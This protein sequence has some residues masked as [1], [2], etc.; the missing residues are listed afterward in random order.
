[1]W[2]L[3]QLHTRHWQGLSQSVDRLLH[4][5][6]AEVGQ[7]L[8]PG[9]Q[10]GYQRRLDD[11]MDWIEEQLDQPLSVDM[12]AE[13]G[14]LS[15][16]RLFQLF[17]QHLHQSPMQYVQT[18]RMDRARAYLKNPY[19]SVKQV[20]TRCGYPDANLFVRTFKRHHNLPPGKWRLKHVL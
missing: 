16:S 1:M 14:Q 13:Q 10:T 15:A 9:K 7:Q 6:L 18:Q 17:D 12:L 5:L 3:L 20:A 4:V 19:L 2:S 11:L 8:R